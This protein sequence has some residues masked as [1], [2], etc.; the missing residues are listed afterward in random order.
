MGIDYADKVSQ[1]V[2][3]DAGGRELG[4]RRLRSETGR[5]VAYGE[6]FG[7]IVGVAIEAC[8]GTATL[9]DELIQRYGW[10]VQ[11][12]HPGFVR[13]MKRNPDKTDYSDARV[14]ADL[15]RVGYLPPVWL[16]PSHI[17]ELRRVT[18]GRQSMVE[19]GRRTKLRVRALLRD[20]R[21]SK[22][23]G[24]L[25]VWTKCGLSWLHALRL[26]ERLPSESRWLLE[27][28]LNHLRFVDEELAAFKEWL[29]SI[30]ADDPLIQRLLEQRG[31][32]LI[33]A[34]VLRAEIGQ[35][36][37]FGSGKQ[38]AHY[39][40]VSP[41]NASSGER[42]ADAGL[43]RGGNRQL[44]LALIELAHRVKRYDPHW[45]ALAAR[46]LRAGKPR[47]VIVAAVANRWIRKL[48]YQMLPS[49]LAA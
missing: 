15:C 24:L 6:R 21:I 14:L 13:R 28:H 32:G 19:E 3:L 5:L 34:C 33:T 9:A 11:L 39:C 47:C 12:A 48:Y 35:F 27:R 4:T 10:P 20:H 18:R 26:D 2:V 25:R 40:G 44:K 46:L 42:Q 8:C 31:V 23:E 43:V 17:R 7:P 41:Q 1:V 49:T 36:E 45:C 38:L 37:R 29:E 30:A 16:A 22:P